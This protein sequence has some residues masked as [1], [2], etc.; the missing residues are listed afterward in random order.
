MK[1]SKDKKSTIAKL[2]FTACVFTICFLG[3]LTNLGR[4]LVVHGK[5][6]SE[7]AYNNQMKNQI[8]SP[9]RGIIYDVNG[10]V[11][12]MS[13]SVETIS[14][15][16]G[17]I[18]YSNKKNVPNEIIAEGLATTLELD[19]NEVLEKVNKKSSV[20][21]IAKKVSEEKAEALKTWLNEKKITTGIN[22]D[23]DTKRYYPY[24]TVASNLIGICNADNVR[25]HWHRKSLEQHTNR[26]SWQN[27]CH[28][29][30]QEKPNF[31]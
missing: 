13:I 22:I 30:C 25:Y 12:A 10:N 16:P 1:K 29:R 7:S 24:N 8:I 26:N 14:I 23:K 17:Q 9:K 2:A 11:L 4:I 31:R 6:Y 3:I 15:N 20:V 28:A 18:F 19:Y 21:V 5:E 27:C